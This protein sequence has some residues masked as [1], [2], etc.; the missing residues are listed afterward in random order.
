M[1][2]IPVRQPSL[3][4]EQEEPPREVET[5]EVPNIS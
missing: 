3:L 2:T 4:R 5:D 1:Q